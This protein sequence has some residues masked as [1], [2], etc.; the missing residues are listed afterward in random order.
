MSQL[1]GAAL[2]HID[3]LQQFDDPQIVDAEQ[4]AYGAEQIVSRGIVFA[5]H[6]L[7]EVARSRGAS[8]AGLGEGLHDLADGQRIKRSGGGGG[9]SSSST[10]AELFHSREPEISPKY[11]ARWTVTRVGAARESLDIAEFLSR[12][13]IHRPAKC[14]W[15][16][17]RLWLGTPIPAAEC[18]ATYRCCVRRDRRSTA[19]AT[20]CAVEGFP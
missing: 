13:E 2:E 14:R 15:A 10:H 16:L 3:Q 19:G 18:A 12:S 9:R 6:A 11:W 4:L 20:N 5:D 1:C 17:V 8:A 7:D